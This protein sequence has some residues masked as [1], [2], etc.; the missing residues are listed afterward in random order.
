MSFHP[1]QRGDSK[2]NKQSGNLSD[3]I[4]IPGVVS[5]ET[6]QMQQLT[7]NCMFNRI[8]V[9]EWRGVLMNCELGRK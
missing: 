9:G 4:A 8:C 3:L 7:E 5:F 1:R 6:T 2:I